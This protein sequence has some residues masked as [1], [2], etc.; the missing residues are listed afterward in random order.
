MNFTQV[1]L[2]QLD[3]DEDHSLFP[4]EKPVL[5]IADKVSFSLKQHVVL[6]GLELSTDQQLHAKRVNLKVL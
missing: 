1:V 3:C 4:G 6:V 2:V 5:G